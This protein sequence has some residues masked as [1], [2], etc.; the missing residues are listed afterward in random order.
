MTIDQPDQPDSQPERLFNQADVNKMLAE[1][2]RTM[3]ARIAELESRPDLESAMAIERGKWQSQIDGLGDGRAAAITQRESELTT[4]WETKLSERDALHHV[5][6]TDLQSRH[7]EAE[8]K[9][10]ALTSQYHGHKI[11]HDLLSAASQGD[12]VVPEQVA[13]L[14]DRF[15]TVVDDR[16]VITVGDRSMSPSEAVESM[17]LEPSKFGNLFRSQMVSG[18]GGSKS[19][20]PPGK[21]DVARMTP[22]E[23]RAARKNNPSSVGFR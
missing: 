19:V 23:Y 13:S 11:K 9:Y 8:T 12:A 21:V 5:A 22:E 2:K 1:H 3:Q 20:V 7:S 17:R 15:A 10:Q 4:Q 18:V 16:V 6:L 14:L